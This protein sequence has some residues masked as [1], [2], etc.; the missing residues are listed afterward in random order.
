M[1]PA[2]ILDELRAPTPGLPD[3]AILAAMEAPGEVSPGLVAILDEALADPET[4]LEDDVHASHLIA[5]FLLA[6]FREPL[7]LPPLLAMLRLTEEEQDELLGDFLTEGL[8]SVLASLCLEDPTPLAALAGDPELDL[9]VRNAAMDAILVL[10]FLG[11]LSASR[12][13]G[14]FDGLLTAFEERGAEEDPLAWANLVSS[15]SLAGFEALL[16]RL[17]EAFALGLVADEVI[18]PEELEEGFTRNQAHYR[19]RFL[20]EHHLVEDALLELE[21]RSWI[22]SEE[23]ALA[24]LELEDEDEDGDEDGDEDDPN[25]DE[26]IPIPAPSPE[27]RQAVVARQGHTAP[28]PGQPSRNAPCPCGSG[29]KYKRCCGKG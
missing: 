14:I 27:T 29:K 24:D 9:Y 26:D 17:R 19:R 1:T 18:D 11:H 3:D 6:Q 21:A 25:L 16:P 22:A 8:A 12:F 10:G 2:L 4:F 20:K 15:C 7:A 13:Q 28:T 5:L 23:D